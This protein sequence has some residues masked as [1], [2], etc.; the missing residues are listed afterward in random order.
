MF[1]KNT[2]YYELKIKRIEQAI[3]RTLSDLREATD[4]FDNRGVEA[5]SA[6]LYSC[7]QVLA[8]TKEEC[9][10]WK[11]LPPCCNECNTRRGICHA[12]TVRGSKTCLK[13][14]RSIKERAK[15]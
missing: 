4:R 3:V 10:V 2:E 5:Q 1:T 11:N 7:E 14:R 9:E 8:R 13:N 6:Y 15:N 12:N